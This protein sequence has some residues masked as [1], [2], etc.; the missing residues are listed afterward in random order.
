VVVDTPEHAAFFAS[1]T[2]RGID[3][4]AVL[5]VGADESLYRPAPD[6]GDAAPILWY[7]TYIPLHGFDTV[8]RAAALLARTD[9]GR[10]LR[11]VGDGQDRATAEAVAKEMGLHNI[12]FVDAVPE[13]ELPDEISRAS[14]CLGVFGTSDKAS[15]VVPNKVFQCAAASRAIVT[16]ETPAIRTAFGD[17]LVTVPVADAEALAEALR[18]LHGEARLQAA[19]RARE[20][21]ATRFSDAALARDLDRVLGGLL[22]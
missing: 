16:A 4:F 6:A 15:R 3:K 11:L 20:V 19:A 22:R 18:S 5:W 2:R 17:A 9:P 7:L 8:A 13:R 1:F 14:I 21:F 12:E 10:T